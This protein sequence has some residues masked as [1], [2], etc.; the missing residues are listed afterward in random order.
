MSDP[1][2]TPNN[3]PTD[4]PAAPGAP[5]TGTDPATAKGADRGADT[6]KR[7][8]RAAK[9]AY[10]A[11]T[12]V[13]PARPPMA[14][15]SL[16]RVVLGVMGLVWMVIGLWALADPRSLA[17]IV[18]LRIDSALGRLE[19]RAMYGGFSVALGLLHGVAASRRAWLAQGLVVT[20]FLTTGLLSGRLLTVALEGVPG[21]TALMMIGA[22]SAGLT[23]VAV[24]LWRL[25]VAT[26]AAKK[27][28]KNAAKQAAA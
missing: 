13:S 14:A 3:T 24:A 27:V 1:A 19:I 8:A 7:D 18:D 4:D 9:T 10:V 25:L 22:E 15:E 11:V 5:T 21:P 20:G 12:G 26:R 28:V 17:D 6:T 16:A 2:T 23:L